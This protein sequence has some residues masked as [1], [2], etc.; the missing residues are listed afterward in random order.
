MKEKF[1]TAFMGPTTSYEC[2][3]AEEQAADL[4]RIFKESGGMMSQEELLELV[5]KKKNQLKPL[6]FEKVCMQYLGMYKQTTCEV[7]DGLNFGAFLPLGNNFQLGG[8]W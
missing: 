2:A 8:Q 4:E 1:Q 6:P 5:M 7:P 3:S